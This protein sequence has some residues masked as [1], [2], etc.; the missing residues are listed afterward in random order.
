MG[1]VR[2]KIAAASSWDTAFE[3]AMM[4]VETGLQQ[5]DFEANDTYALV[6]L[7]FPGFSE[8]RHLSPIIDAIEA[9]HRGER[10]CAVIAAPPQHGKT[11]SIKTALARM[12]ALG[13][14][15]DHSGY[16]TYNDTKGQHESKKTRELLTQAG[17][18]TR[19]NLHLWEGPRGADVLFSGVGGSVNGFPFN[20]LA[21]LDD[22]LKNRKEAESLTIRNNVWD[23]T[24]SVFTTR[25][26]PGTSKLIVATRWHPDDPSGRAVN[27]WGWDYINLSA[28]DDDG[29]ALWP[30]GRPLSF[31]R[32]VEGNLG[33]YDWNSLYQGNPVP[34][35]GSVFGAPYYYDKL[36]D[37]YAVAYGCDLAYTSKSSSDWSILVRGLWDGRCLYVTDVWRR[38]IKAP[39][40]LALMVNEC[41][42][43]PGPILWHC[44]GTEKG[45]AQFAADALAKPLAKAGCRFLYW[46]AASDKFIRAQPASSAWD[47]G[48]ILLPSKHAKRRDGRRFWINDNTQ[49][50]WMPRFIGTV[51]GFTGVKDLEDDDV[52]AL[53]SLYT[54]VS[55]GGK[56]RKR[57]TN[58]YSIG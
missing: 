58:G 41:G 49:P 53:S 20:K 15:Q 1:F 18:K 56:R 37:N 6:P 24:K 50:P 27:Q 25:C 54:L 33:P 55:T 16:V 38:Q 28:I 23:F 40:F 11:V 12:A 3:R 14:R 30:Q 19:G 31:L 43:D 35:G 8:P 26:H 9:A 5:V 4:S 29:V 32:E 39:H 7:L 36:P 42:Q 10:I 44:S 52:D 21:V 51:C 46:P 17:L 45:V 48:R 13:G 34:R 2:E 22:G 47:A 57:N